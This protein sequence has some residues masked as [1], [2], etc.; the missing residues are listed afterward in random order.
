[1]GTA[2]STMIM[3]EQDLLALKKNTHQRGKQRQQAG[4]RNRARVFCRAGSPPSTSALRTAAHDH[5]HKDIEPTTAA[6]CST[7]DVAES[8]SSRPTM[9]AKPTP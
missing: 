2:S 4:R 3:L 9:G 8:P 1:M 7:H 5:R 6:A